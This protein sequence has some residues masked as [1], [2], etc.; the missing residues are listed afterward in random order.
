[1]AY[2]DSEPPVCCIDNIIDDLK[3]S[4]VGYR[5]IRVDPS[6]FIDFTLNSNYPKRY[7]EIFG[8][9]Y[10]EKL[11]EHF[12]SEKLLGFN[13][14]DVFVDIAASNSDF[15][16]YIFGKYDAESY[17]QD[18]VYKNGIYSDT[19]SIV[20]LIGGNASDLPFK[21]R[22]VTKMTL[23]CSI[24]H[25][26]NKDDILFMKEGERVLKPNGKICILPLYFGEIY[27]LVTDPEVYKMN[28]DNIAFEEGVDV[29]K[30]EGYGNRHCRVY[31]V[32]KF[33]Q[34]LLAQNNFKVEI[35]HITNLGEIDPTLYCSFAAILSKRE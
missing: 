23:H 10:K 29:Y 28:K 17:K 30:K 8:R 20:P 3:N 34:R 18:L 7:R 4:D 32:E 5:T 25:F 12:I 22:Y 35:Y 6:E 11:F 27:H 21:D 33:K 19:G 1:M 15:A 16:D 2:I 13:G 14:Q 9:Y 26:E 24:E 31:T